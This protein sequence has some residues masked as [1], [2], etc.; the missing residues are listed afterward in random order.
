MPPV[1]PPPDADAGGLPALEL[2]WLGVGGAVAPLCRHCHLC[3]HHLLDVAANPLV[4]Y[5]SL[6]PPGS[7]RRLMQSLVIVGDALLVMVR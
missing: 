3:R 6:S 2:A 5:S 7:M 4:S 1:R